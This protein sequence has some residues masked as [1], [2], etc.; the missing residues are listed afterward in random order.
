MTRKGEQIDRILLG[1]CEWMEK[2]SNCINALR[3]FSSGEMVSRM[4]DE[5]E[6]AGGGIGY[7]STVLVK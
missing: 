6:G 5:G 4:D 3:H 1:V 2:E 7:P